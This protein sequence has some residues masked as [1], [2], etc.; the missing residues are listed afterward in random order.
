MA[1]TGRILRARILEKS[2][3]RVQV[4]RKFIRQFSLP[5][6]DVSRAAE[7]QADLQLLDDFRPR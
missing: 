1:H 3:D 7:V 5:S 2:P 4:L 6:W